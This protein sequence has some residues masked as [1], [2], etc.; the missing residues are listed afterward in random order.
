MEWLD[1]VEL[2]TPPG[3]NSVRGFLYS[4]IAVLSNGRRV[5]FMNKQEG[6]KTIY[7]TYSDDGVNWSTPQLFEPCNFVIGL[8]SPKVI[9]DHLDRIHIIWASQLP[10]ALYYSQMDAELNYVIDSVLISDNPDF[11]TFRDM[12]ITADLQGRIHV[13]W[14]EGITGVHLP[15]AHYSRS[16]DG[17]QS[18]SDEV[19]LSNPDNLPSSFPRTQLNAYSG[20]TLAIFWRDSVPG[21]TENWD[22]QMV[23]SMDGGQSWSSPTVIAPNVNLQG[24]PDLVIDP[25]GRFHLFFHEAPVSDA[26]W[27]MRVRY[28]YSDDL[29]QT[30]LPSQNFDNIICNDQR[31]YL[32]EGSRYDIQNDVLWTFWKEEDIPGLQ[33]GDMMAAYSLDRGESWSDPEYVTDWG[34]PSIGFKAVA[35]LPNGGIAANYELPNYPSSG[36][37]RIFYK[38]REPLLV[39]TA[40][41]LYFEKLLIYPNPAT[42]SVF[43]QGLDGTSAAELIISDIWGR[44]LKTISTNENAVVVEVSELPPGIYFLTVYDVATKL[45]HTE[46]FLKSE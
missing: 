31:S 34:D 25:Q 19:L 5:V 15:E 2:P 11:D 30:W 33:G 20:D 37:F 9:S 28:G 27:G 8:N 45:M 46:K 32:V 4:N 26:Y 16:V 18:W 14:N 39:P 13:M 41:K 44:N 21:P 7:Y 40:E 3:S 12:Y 23:L 1:D 10:R 17:G 6:G 22:L 43:V 24:D 42:S 29:G 38:E 36:L 35:L